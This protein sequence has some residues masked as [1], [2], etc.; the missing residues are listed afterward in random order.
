MGNVTGRYREQEEG[1]DGNWGWYVKYILKNKIKKDYTNKQK[2]N[3]IK[4]TLFPYWSFSHL[5]NVKFSVP[6]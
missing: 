4:F 3:L 1:K 2:L 6:V 5:N